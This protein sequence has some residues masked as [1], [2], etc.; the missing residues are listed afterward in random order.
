MSGYQEDPPA[1]AADFQAVV[2]LAEEIAFRDI[3]PIIPERIAVKL[4]DRGMHPSL[5][6]LGTRDPLAY[7]HRIAQAAPK[8][9]E[10]C[11][12]E[13]QELENIWSVENPAE[14]RS[15]LRELVLH[16]SA[17]G[18]PVVFASI[19][20]ESVARNSIRS[21]LALTHGYSVI[22]R[23]EYS[24]SPDAYGASVK[25][26]IESLPSGTK[27]VVVAHEEIASH[28]TIEAVTKS[29]I[30]VGSTKDARYSGD[31]P[32]TD[33]IDLA[34]Q[35]NLMPSEAASIE[36]VGRIR[37]RIFSLKKKGREV[38]LSDA[39]MAEYGDLTGGFSVISNSGEFGFVDQKVGQENAQRIE[40]TRTLAA[41]GEHLLEVVSIDAALIE[42]EL[43]NWLIIHRSRGF[44][45]SERITFGQTVQ[46]AENNGFP[47][48]LIARLR[49]FN[50]LRNDAVHHLA[51]GVA[52][53]ADLIGQYVEDC[54]LLFDIR[55]F[56]LASAPRIG[57]NP[58]GLY[59]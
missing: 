27:T 57:F 52:S 42:I 35:C 59:Q 30:K 13:Y 23:Q 6:S 16:L 39:E 43:R 21:G 3:K 56:V 11:D 38:G 18:V 49:T 32:P 15:G 4:L 26:A 54:V 48:A 29:L 33:I 40:F 7:M 34:L 47:S 25:N 19:K 45:P 8:F 5:H 22:G 24:S 36:K 1:F 41:K 14:P 10:I 28:G 51:R 17:A 2:I 9:L 31:R 12:K 58:V 37:D 46:L 55:E 50:K 20:S 44:Q 53:Y